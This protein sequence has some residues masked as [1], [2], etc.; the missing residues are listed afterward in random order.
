MWVCVY[1]SSSDHL[2]PEYYAAAREL[3]VGLAQRGWGLVYGG[4]S[5]G[6]MGALARAVHS[7][8]GQVMGV[9]PQ[10]LLDR[11]V[12]YLEAD[13]LVVTTTMRERK[14][15]MD[16]RAEAFVTLPG[17][18]GTLEELLEILTLRQLGYHNKPIIIVNLSGYFTPLL[19][20]FERIF[21]Q[22]FTAQRFR[23][24][25]TVVSTIEEAF[26]ALEALGR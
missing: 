16:E 21:A 20:Q 10:A 8:G 15:L 2:A 4:G 11:E 17:G 22:Q 3:G 24:L 14:R 1:C 5:I 25:Y 26:S 6:M 7:A 23:D 13:E 9:I 12:G 18:F 19:E